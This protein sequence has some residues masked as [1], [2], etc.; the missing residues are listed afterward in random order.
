MSEQWRPVNPWLPDIMSRRHAHITPL[1]CS[2]GRTETLLAPFE[3]EKRLGAMDGRAFDV[4]GH[5]EKARQGRPDGLSLRKGGSFS[6]SA[7]Q[8]NG[9]CLFDEPSLCDSAQR[10]ERANHSYAHLLADS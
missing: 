7:S 1:D 3:Q 8:V 10:I 6:V 9:E 5:K 2:S 4:S